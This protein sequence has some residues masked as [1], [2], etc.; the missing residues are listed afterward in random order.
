[1]YNVSVTLLWNTGTQFMI[2][3]MFMLIN[4]IEEFQWLPW[5]NEELAK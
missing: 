2:Q 5:S 4:A 3:Y 1:M